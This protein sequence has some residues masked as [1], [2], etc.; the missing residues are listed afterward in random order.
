M[1]SI[2]SD[3]SHR[4]RNSN[5]FEKIIVLNILVYI[6]YIILKL[7]SITYINEYFALT[8]DYIYN[9]WSLLTYAFIHEGLYEL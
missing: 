7:S 9:P 4:F 3:I 8:H 5:S 2:F 6:F 1:S